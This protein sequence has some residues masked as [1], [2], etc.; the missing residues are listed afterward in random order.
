MGNLD[1]I[2]NDLKA[3]DEIR[4]DYAHASGG[5]TLSG[6]VNFQRSMLRETVNVGGLSF[7]FRPVKGDLLPDPYKPVPALTAITVI[8][9]AQRP[10]FINSDAKREP[11]V[12]DVVRTVY[13]SLYY[14]DGT[15]FRSIGYRDS[16][17]RI[18][19]LREFNGERGTLNLVSEGV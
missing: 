4:A 8:R 5:F 15:S 16:V 2:V 7:A 10:W 6:I 3:G 19:T 14:F 1:H 11:R 12:N 9:R 13:G 17:S 18:Y